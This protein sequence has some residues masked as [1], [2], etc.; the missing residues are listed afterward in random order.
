MKYFLITIFFVAAALTASAQTI[1]NKLQ[2]YFALSSDN[3]MY[4]Y[5][6]F[7]GNGKVD[8]SGWGD[9]YY[10][11]VND[12]VIVYPDKSLFKFVLKDNKLAGASNW[13]K[14]QS[15]ILK[16]T[17]IEQQ[18]ITA[19]D[20]NQANLLY[21]YYLLNNRDEKIATVLTADATYTNGLRELCDSGLIK[22]CATLF[23][24]KIINS[25][26]F[27][28]L[29]DSKKKVVKKD[30]DPEILKIGQRVIDLGDA[31][32]YGYLGQ[33]YSMIGDEEKAIQL[34]KEGDEKGCVKCALA[35]LSLEA[36]KEEPA[37]KPLKKK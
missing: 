25:D 5:F 1:S 14:E 9:G 8:I 28:T 30:A 29:F 31:N 16:D 33:Y 32:G 12:T 34:L 3:S 21:K 36:G 23:G 4:E 27:E 22:S 19:A 2:G 26:L 24:V 10:F 15:W 11:Q 7:H 20:A 13:V 37:K 17:T 35:L 6:N 18:E